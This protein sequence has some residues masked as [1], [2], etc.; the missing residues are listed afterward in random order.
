MLVCA[1]LPIFFLEIALGQYAGVGPIKIFGRL[2]PILKGL[3]YSV[4][5]V[6]ILLAFYYN[7]VVSWSLKYLSTALSAL[8]IDYGKLEW[9][10]PKNTSETCS[11]TNG[12]NFTTECVC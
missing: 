7:V 6:G 11:Q 8:I 5:M 10:N 9:C 12:S 1:G 4:V 2:A 3:G